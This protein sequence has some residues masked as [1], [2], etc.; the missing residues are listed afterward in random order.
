MTEI[1]LMLCL[2]VLGLSGMLLTTRR[3]LREER[4]ARLAFQENVKKLLQD[5]ADQV[6]AG[7]ALLETTNVAMNS[8][9]SVLDTK[10]H[11]LAATQ[12]LV[13]VNGLWQWETVISN[14]S[15]QKAKPAVKKSPV[16]K[17]VK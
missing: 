14:P 6:D 3:D 8:N 4:A 2:A 5:I 10:I 17:G 11:A 9:L 13:S 15:T 12:G 16:K 1:I 7:T